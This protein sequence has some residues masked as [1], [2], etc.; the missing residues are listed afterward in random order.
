MTEIRVTPVV[1]ALIKRGLDLKPWLKK[2]FSGDWG[3]ISE[4]ERTL[5]IRS[6][7]NGD[8]H[9][10]SVYHPDAKITLWITTKA[11]VTL[12]MLPLA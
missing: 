8:G 11:G 3:D 1:A 12:V 9:V 5:N 6:L 10:L 7:D 2:H 4:T